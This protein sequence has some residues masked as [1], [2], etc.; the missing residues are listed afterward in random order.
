MLAGLKIEHIVDC[1]IYPRGFSNYLK[2]FRFSKDDTWKKAIHAGILVST[3]I[4]TY[5]VVLI[6][7]ISC[8]VV[9]D[10]HMLP[11]NLESFLNRMN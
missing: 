6:N 3:I 11:I 7:H 8:P 4:S 10:N 9:Q 1:I 2:Q 5:V